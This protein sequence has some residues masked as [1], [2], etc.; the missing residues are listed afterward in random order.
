MLNAELINIRQ[1]QAMNQLAMVKILKKHDK[2]SG[3]KYVN[4]IVPSVDASTQ[5]LNNRLQRKLHL[6]GF[7]EHKHAFQ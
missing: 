1:F 4:Y 2:R 6:S 7:G 5:M 3:L